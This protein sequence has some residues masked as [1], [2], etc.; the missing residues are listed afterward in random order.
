LEPEEIS[1]HHSAPVRYK[2]RYW[3][4]IL[5]FLVTI[6]TTVFA[7]GQMVGRYDYYEA[8]NT[9]TTII[10]IPLN[11]A[12]LLDGLR[13]SFSLLLFLTVHEFGHY[14][15]ARRHH[16]QTSLPYFI[17]FPFN[18]IG[19]FGAVIRIRER[20]PSMTKLFDIGAAGPIAGFFV[21]VLVL[22][23]GL[24]TLPP[25]DYVMDFGEHQALQSHIEEFGEFP[26]EIPD[27]PLSENSTVLVVGS[28]PLYWFLTQFF[29][30]VPPLWEMY[31][32][33]FLFAG[34]LGLFFTA[35]NLLPV[36]Q[37]DGGHMLFALV[38]PRWHRVLARVFVGFLLI[39]GG[40]GF[41]TDVGPS[42][43]EA[44]SD[45]I[46]SP[47]VS[48][49]LAPWVVLSAIMIFYLQR[50]FNYNT[51]VVVASLFGVMGL[52]AVLSWN[53]RIVDSF[54]YSGWLFWCLLIVVLIRVDHPEVEEMEPLSPGRKALAIFGLIIF[55]L[56]FSIKPLYFV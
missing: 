47:A 29:D 11:G 9:W 14:L 30:D 49:T 31:H 44:F 54:G 27:H 17:P 13:F 32:Y 22:L 33:P 52:I 42:I 55:A 12:F 25:L 38:G 48:G 43:S 53:P 15:V 51:P 35:V 1:E 23:Y 41:V 8:S 50:I 40:I 39:S 6:V 37:L 21:A 36:G 46:S 19:T 5:L 2:D 28:T 56:C 18:G 24:I 7:G 16:I 4:H 26:S 34:W 10:G 3:L 45:W 20:I